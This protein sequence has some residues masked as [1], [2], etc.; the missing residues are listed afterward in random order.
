MNEALKLVL[1]QLEWKSLGQTDWI[2][3][4]RTTAM[5]VNVA[6]NIHKKT[7]TEN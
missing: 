2:F 6:R 4:Q 7:Q 1:K 3:L 5:I